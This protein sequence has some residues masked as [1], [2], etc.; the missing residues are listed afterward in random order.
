[1]TG[2]DHAFVTPAGRTVQLR[3]DG[4]RAGAPLVLLNGAAF[5][6]GQWQ[7]LVDKGGWTKAHHVI[8]YNYAGTGGSSPRPG[9]VGVEVL[10]EELCDL[11]DGLGIPRAHFYGI[12]QGTIVLQALA[13]RA[14]ERILSAAGYGWFYGGHS[15]IE[16][17]AARIAERLGPLEQLRDLFDAPLD[18]GG[19]EALWDKVYRPALTG[20]SSWAALSFAQRLKDPVLRHVLYPLLRPTPIGQ[21][22]EW[23]AYC[24]EG[25][26]ADEPVLRDGLAALASRPVLLQHATADETLPVGMAREL[27]TVLPGAKYREY[28][29]GYTHTSIAFSTA[30]ARQIV[31]EHCRFMAAAAG[32]PRPISASSRA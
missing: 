27:S 7:R 25:L 6:L 31:Q 3:H 10:A 9:P 32:G 8:R 13:A 18:R 28:G 16:Q 2:S 12:S 17:V 14:P 19:F 29:A 26:R 23:F 30:Q 20:A 15:Q 24:A 4:T 22:H 1:M 11:L 5:H 21:I